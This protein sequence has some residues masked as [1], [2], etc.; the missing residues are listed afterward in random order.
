MEHDYLNPYLINCYLYCKRRYYYEA[1]LDINLRNEEIK[2]GTYKHERMEEK[3]HKKSLFLI[4]D[5]LGIKGK[6]DYVEERYN[7][8]IPIEVKKGTAMRPYKNDVYQLVSYAALLHESLNI[9]I[10]R[11][12][13][14]YSGSKKKFEIDINSEKYEKLKLIINEIK[15]FKPEK[16][17][18]K[19][20]NRSKCLKCSLYDYCYL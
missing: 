20:R 12:I 14:L 3:Y 4:S 1:L 16:I 9:E 17:P 5:K 6:I 8:V 13:L 2:E 19:T 10:K 11:G 7:E 18:E 15:N